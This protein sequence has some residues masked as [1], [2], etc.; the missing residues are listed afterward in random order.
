MLEI[1]SQ[2]RSGKLVAPGTREHLELSP[3]SDCLVGLSSGQEF[4]FLN[5]HVPVL[6]RDENWAAKY[7]A[8]ASQM[9]EEY[10]SEEEQPVSTALS[11]KAQTIY[12]AKAD[13]AVK[14]LL[15]ALPDTALCL[16]V[17]GGPVRAHPKLC[18][19]NIGPFPNVDVV[20]DA[21]DLP[22]SDGCVDAIYCSAVLEHLHAPE[23]AVQEMFRVLKPGGRLYASSPFIFVYHGYPNHYQN[24]T[25]TGHRHLFERHGFTLIEDGI[26]V[27]PAYAV[28]QI[29]DQFIHHFTTGFSHWAF[30]RLWRLAVPFIR[31]I[32]QRHDHAEKAYLLASTT[33]VIAEKP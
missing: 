27:G 26:S 12:T 30:K 25:L 29:V 16:S 31:R 6:L 3:D 1:L 8:Q 17:G 2:I 21:H 24:Y 10:E 11:K 9:L 5:G 20:G 23:R 7:V 33:Y 13:Q 19:L 32:D 15:D 18:N 22:Y 4:K 14:N 28:T